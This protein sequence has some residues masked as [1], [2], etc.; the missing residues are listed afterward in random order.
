MMPRP[1]KTGVTGMVPF[2]IPGMDA[3][4]NKPKGKMTAYAFFVQI[5]RDEHKRKHPDEQ[6]S[7]NEF[8]KKCSERWKTMTEKEKRRFNQM[9]DADKK[10]FKEELKRTRDHNAPKKPMSAFFWFCEV[11]R[12]KIQEIRK[13]QGKEK[14]GLTELSKELGKQWTRQTEETKAAFQ[15]LVDKDKDRYRKELREY[16]ESQRN[17]KQKI[18]KIEPPKKEHNISAPSKLLIFDDDVAEEEMNI[19]DNFE[20]KATNT[21]KQ[22]EK[23]SECNNQSDEKTEQK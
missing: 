2:G 6:V 15:I 23:E 3:N 14:L 18:V 7:L 19:C 1:G 12:P 13:D 8:T 11:A 21:G 17:K 10:L 20:Q 4:D 9:A 5:C 22:L 16:Q